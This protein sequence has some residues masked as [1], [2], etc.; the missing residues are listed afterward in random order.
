MTRDLSAGTG[1]DG[2]NLL[3]FL[4]AVGAFSTLHRTM[5][6]REVLMSWLPHTGWRAGIYIDGEILTI[7]DCETLFAELESRRSY[8]KF[9][10]RR[11]E[12]SKGS[13]ARRKAGR[14]DN[15][16]DIEIPDFRN[17][18]MLALRKSTIE[19]RALVD[20]IA[21]LGCDVPGKDNCIRDTAFRTLYGASNQNFFTTML[22]LSGR[23]KE[24]SRATTL[25]HV[26]QALLGQWEYADA[27]GGMR[28][29][30][31]EDRQH[32]L[33]PRD[34]S[35]DII[36][37]E[38]GANRLAIEALSLFPTAPGHRELQTCGFHEE[39]G[40]HFF[41]WPMW[42]PRLSLDAV[43]TLLTQSELSRLHPRRETLAPLGV[44]EVFRVERIQKG[45]QR[46]FSVASPILK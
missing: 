9:L 45:R 15:V 6:D 7:A 21:S 14:Y 12:P 4:C 17:H 29:D 28:W 36:W 24:R 35:P 5:P 18:A 34:P 19:R 22:Q 46:N 39:D 44:E 40:R 37:T 25:A 2:S 13:S 23:G 41:S 27:K 42:T 38:R 20:W 26:E 30:S 43:K 3:G 10:V 1:S 11:T 16:H 31:S 33:R 32:A 8:R